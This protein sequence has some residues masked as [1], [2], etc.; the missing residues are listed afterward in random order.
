MN[1]FFIPIVVAIGITACST[2]EL[3]THDRTS[4]YDLNKPSA[5]AVLPD[6]LHEV[7][8]LTDIDDHT[9]ACIQDENGVLF[10][11]DLLTN[12]IKE[13][14]QFHIDG[15]Y[16]GV[17]RVGDAM[18]ILR[19]DATLFKV[20]HYRQNEFTLYTYPTGIPAKNNEGLCYDEAN[21]RL[22][23]ACKSKLG[24][25]SIFKDKR[26][27]YAFDVASSTLLPDPVFEFDLQVI[28]DFAIAK[29]IDLPVRTKKS[30]ECAVEVPVLKFSSSAISVHPIRNELYVLS[31]ADHLFFI[32]DMQGKIIH[33]EAIDPNVFN[34]AEGITF[35]ANGDM[36]IS[37][38]G[39][40][41]NPTLLRFNYR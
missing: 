34:K 35:L 15:D 33:M 29:K 24:K 13:Q 39:Q 9:V 41:G 30:K 6:T 40:D 5:I 3:T 7:S 18:F 4:G 21:N 12:S 1:N 28:K 36:L 11:Y 20:D 2:T 31:A 10:F 14:F 17:T 37:N 23:I 8:G 16:E 32:F 38:E 26:A 25:G 27:I 19:S 22:L